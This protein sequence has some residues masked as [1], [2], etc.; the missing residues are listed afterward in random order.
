MSPQANPKLVYAMTLPAK[1]TA[2]QGSR[3]TTINLHRP[4]RR[5]AMPSAARKAV[6]P[7]N[8]VGDFGGGGQCAG[9]RMVCGLARAQ[10]SG[11]APGWSTPPWSM[12][13]LGCSARLRHWRAPPVGTTRSAEPTCIEAER[14]STGTYETKGRQVRLDRLDRAA[15]L[16]L[17]LEKTGLHNETLP[18]QMDRGAWGALKTKLKASFKRPRPR[19]EWCAVMEGTDICFA[20]LLT[21][22]EAPHHPHAKDAAPMSMSRGLPSHPRP[23][24]SRTKEAVQGPAAKRG[25][26]T[27]AGACV[28]RVLP[29]RRS[30]DSRQPGSPP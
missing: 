12:R 4:H 24:F 13:G 5:A 28:K 25:E 29:R 6:P 30:S 15:I 1:G 23:R 21:M 14:I 26:H 20:P 8:L 19:D 18:K 9:L 10:K 2:R 16:R 27:T 11:K 3:V 17:L 22:S 7:L